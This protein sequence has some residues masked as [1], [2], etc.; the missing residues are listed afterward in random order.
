MLR[1]FMMSLAV[2]ATAVLAGSGTS[3]AA[4]QVLGLTASLAPITLPCDADSCTALAGTFC[5]QHERVMPTTGTLYRATR[6][7]R[8]TLVLFDRAGEALR[9]AGDHWISITAYD[10]YT[11]VRMSVPRRVLDE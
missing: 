10:G 4:P 6:P 5:L 9:I 3:S 11:M 2:W 1:R 7:D 8:L